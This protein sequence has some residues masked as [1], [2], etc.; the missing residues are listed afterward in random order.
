MFTGWFDEIGLHVLL[1][2][3]LYALL[4]VF[5]KPEDQVSVGVHEPTGNCKQTSNMYTALGQVTSVCACVC[6]CVRVCVCAYLWA[7]VWVCVRVCVLG[8]GDWL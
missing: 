2:Y 8:W 1:H 7:C 3:T 6:V 4:V 5:A